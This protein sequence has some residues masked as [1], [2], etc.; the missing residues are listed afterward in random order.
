MASA[1]PAIFL[2]VQVSLWLGNDRAVQGGAGGAV[3][4]SAV[5]IGKLL[6]V[7]GQT[8]RGWKR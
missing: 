8:V 2:S 4:L 7:P 3:G 5:E 6:G 1:F